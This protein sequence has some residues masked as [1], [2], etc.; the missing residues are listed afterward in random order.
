MKRSD[1][2]WEVGKIAPEGF[3]YEVVA[4]NE[5]LPTDQAAGSV[6]ELLREEFGAQELVLCVNSADVLVAPFS[7]AEDR[8]R[9]QSN[10]LRYAFEEYV[11]FDIEDLTCDFVQSRDRSL[12]VA[13]TTSE[14]RSLVEQLE[15]GDI[16]ITSM[17]PLA[18]LAIQYLAEELAADQNVL[19]LWRVGDRVEQ[20]LLVQQ[21]VLRWSSSECGVRIMQREIEYADL[22][23]GS[24]LQVVACNFPASTI[25]ELQKTTTHEIET[26]SNLDIRDAASRSSQ[27][28]LAGNQNPW[29]EFRRGDLGE[30]DPW[31][32]IRRALNFLTLSACVFFVCL[33]LALWWRAQHYADLSDRYSQEAAKV[34]RTAFPEQ[35]VAG[36]YLRRM[37]SELSQ[38]S[39]TRSEAASQQ[40]PPSAVITLGKALSALPPR[41]KM[42]LR[43]LELRIN[44]PEMYL[45]SQLLSHGETNK[46][47]K[48]LRSVGFEVKPPRSQNLPTTG[49]SVQANA[50]LA[51][52]ESSAIKP[53]R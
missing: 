31:R 30:N 23:H 20:F 6:A 17:A 13:V 25:E 46:L 49:V 24:A 51:Q 21:Q 11:P 35:K 41:N 15:D 4:L 39:G 40:Q 38:L 2:E 48:A 42:R 47:A 5:D 52:D 3:V 45:D 18:M 9:I 43:I 1:G 26:R 28:I 16:R 12:G 29:I 14:Y 19:V 32:P 8:K 44:G 33:N 10:V 50:T 36:G 27:L 53:V 37:E 7:H 22:Q 34:F